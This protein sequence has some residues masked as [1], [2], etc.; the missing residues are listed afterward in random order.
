M[1]KK[2]MFACELVGHFLE[3][4]KHKESCAYLYQTNENIRCPHLSLGH[5]VYSTL[6]MFMIIFFS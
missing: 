4:E 3:R 5:N 2:R 6:K 1:K